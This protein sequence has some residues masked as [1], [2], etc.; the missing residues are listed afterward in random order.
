MYTRMIIG[1]TN[2]YEQVKEFLRIFNADALPEIV[3]LPG[4]VSTRIMTEDDG[5]MIIIESTFETREFT[6]QFA[7]S[8][9]YRQFVARTQ[10]LLIGDFVVKLFQ[11]DPTAVDRYHTDRGFPTKDG[12]LV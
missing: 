8:R 12:K 10:H 2:S 4:H 9:V 11:V 3:L 7:A 6:I 5:C 1:E